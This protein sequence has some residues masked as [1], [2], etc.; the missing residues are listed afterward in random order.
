LTGIS[1]LTA[2]ADRV[3]T[4]NLRDETPEKIAQA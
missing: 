2:F 4:P 1:P 3:E